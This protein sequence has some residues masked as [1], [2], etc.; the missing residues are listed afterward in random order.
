M[1][2]GPRSTDHGPRQVSQADSAGSIPV[3]RS[4]PEKRCRSWRF[5]NFTSSLH[6]DLA[7]DKRALNDRRTIHGPQTRRQHPPSSTW[8]T[9]P[10]QK[11]VRVGNNC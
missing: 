6:A 11:M 8:F 5:T 1:A 4:T 2:A 7:Y 3:T 9:V 10:S